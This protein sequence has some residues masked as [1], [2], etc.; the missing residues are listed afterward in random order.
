MSQTMTIDCNIGN[1]WGW[2]IDFIDEIE[3]ED[4]LLKPQLN[5]SR[6]TSIVT[7]TKKIDNPINNNNNNNNNIN[8]NNIINNIN[9]NNKCFN[10]KYINNLFAEISNV[11]ILGTLYKLI[12]SIINYFN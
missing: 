1:E 5:Y 8:N 7:I 9:N 12:M 4:E 3:V 10:N 6:I 11:L 2:F